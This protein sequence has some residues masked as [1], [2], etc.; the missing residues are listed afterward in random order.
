MDIYPWFSCFL[1]FEP[2]MLAPRCLIF[3]LTAKE[4]WRVTRQH[5]NNM[6]W[7]TV[8]VGQ[9]L[10]SSSTWRHSVVSKSVMEHCVHKYIEAQ[11]EMCRFNL[12]TN[13]DGGCAFPACSLFGCCLTGVWRVCRSAGLEDPRGPDASTQRWDQVLTQRGQGAFTDLV[14]SCQPWLCVRVWL[15]LL[16]FY[17]NYM[18]RL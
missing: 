8:P 14:P 12:M 15:H 18:C 2:K 11:F 3:F 4:A 16:V 17:L 13:W 9:R 7:F 1:W 5:L 6:A 10:I